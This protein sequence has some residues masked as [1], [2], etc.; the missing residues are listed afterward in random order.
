MTDEALT[1]EI[2]LEHEDGIFRAQRWLRGFVSIQANKDSYHVDDENSDVK[3][4]LVGKEITNAPHQAEQA[5]D[6]FHEA[7]MRRIMFTDLEANRKYRFPFSIYTPGSI[8]PS[9]EFTDPKVSGSSCCIEFRLLASF[10]RF[11]AERKIEIVG[12]PLSPK[13]YPATVVP[14]VVPV[15]TKSFSWK[16]MLE[17]KPRHRKQ[18]CSE[19]E[20]HHGCLIWAAHLN[21]THV[22][23]CEEASF[24]FALR[25]NSCYDVI[26]L[27]A[28]L[29]EKISWK[30]HKETSS[31]A[32]ELTYVLMPNQ[33]FLDYQKATLSPRQ[34][35]VVAIDHELAREMEAELG[36]RENTVVVQV[37]SRCRDSY[38]GKLIQVSHHLLIEARTCDTRGQ[39]HTASMTM[40]IPLKVFDPPIMEGHAHHHHHLSA[41]LAEKLMTRWPGEVDEESLHASFTSID[42]SSWG[43]ITNI[44][45]IGE[46]ET[47]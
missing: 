45:R 28:K 46:D 36:L 23:K 47:K 16:K 8:A 40:E 12:Q 9:M 44:P 27:S 32:A 2:S 11:K 4:E 15:V 1:I 17:T 3:I 25:N 20:H 35:Q 39:N 14:S 19:L 29:V 38:K 37:P 13:E 6:V 24:S 26:K 22:G 33:S 21:N 41:D 34:S 42:D 43:S 31:Q 10:Q 30:T 5:V 18:S 7:S